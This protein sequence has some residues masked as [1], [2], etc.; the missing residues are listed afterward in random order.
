MT[1]ETSDLVSRFRAETASRGIPSIEVEYW[2]RA[3]RPAVYAATDGEGPLVAQLGG[4]PMLPGDAPELYG[5]FVGVVDCA[6]L[7]PNAADLP[8]PSEGQLLFFADPEV[9]YDGVEPGRVIYVPAGTPVTRRPVETTS[10]A[11]YESR[12]L[13]TLWH[14]L[15]WPEGPSGY[16]DQ[17]DGHLEGNYALLDQLAAA[18]SHVVGWRPFWTLQIGGHPNSAN[19]DP[20]QVANDEDPDDGDWVLLATW[21]CG[22]DV[23]ELDHGLVHWVIRRQDLA[24]LRFNRVYGTVDMI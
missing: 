8:L 17:G 24:N 1:D 20:V 4:D 7:P 2:I 16:E 13:R 10:R 14:Q 11:P 5:Q 9:G 19:W 21:Q 12:Q 15:S 23:E 22:A 6:L 18:W 3:A